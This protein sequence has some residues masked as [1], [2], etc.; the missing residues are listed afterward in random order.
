METCLENNAV[1]RSGTTDLL[2]GNLWPESVN[3]PGEPVAW[4]WLFGLMGV[5]ALLRI[6]ALNQQL[7][8]D[9]I[10]T[11]LDSARDPISRIVTHYGGQNQHM[12]YSVL[13][14]CS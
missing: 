13:A 4:A 3:F 11:L 14:H 9:E 10:M 1:P 6:V 7:W 2:A 8:F 12:L 5:A